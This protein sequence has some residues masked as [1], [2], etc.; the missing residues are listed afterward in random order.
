VTPVTAVCLPGHSMTYVEQA[1]TQ[2]GNW[3][4]FLHRVYA[5]TANNY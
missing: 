5:H 3:T 1:M 4:Q 2:W